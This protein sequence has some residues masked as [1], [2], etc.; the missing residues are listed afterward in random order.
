MDEIRGTFPSS[1]AATARPLRLFYLFIFFM[2]DIYYSNYKELPKK[3]HT[4]LTKGVKCLLAIFH[5]RFL[6][7]FFFSGNT[8]TLTIAL[9]CP[10][11]VFP[12][13]L[14]VNSPFCV[15]QV[16]SQGERI[17]WFRLDERPIRVKK[18]GEGAVVHNL[19]RATSEKKAE[20]KQRF[21]KIS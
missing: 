8:L 12:Q 14:S 18:R 4:N 15:D 21:K 10:C 3:K 9:P 1:N 13:S 7:Y 17:C 5:K 19:E 20:K 2:Q 6:I 11:T 16:T